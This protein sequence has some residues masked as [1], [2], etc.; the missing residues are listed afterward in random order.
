LR[1]N[2]DN[3]KFSNILA[4]IEKFVPND[5]AVAYRIEAGLQAFITNRQKAWHIGEHP[6][7]VEYYIVQMKKI[8]YIDLNLP[9][10]QEYVRRLE[11]ENFKLLYND[12]ILLIYKNLHPKPIP[13]L[14]S[15]LGWDILLEPIFSWS[16]HTG[17]LQK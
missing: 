11:K 14:E 3:K 9:P 17:T 2:P 13:R 4:I 5:A 1:E 16:R 7:G 15:V 6:E 8:K 12:N 10:L